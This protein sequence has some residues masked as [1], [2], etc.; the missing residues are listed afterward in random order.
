MT[1]LVVLG[2]GEGRTATI[3]VG[4]TTP[5]A[6]L[7]VGPSVVVTGSHGTLVVTDKG[8][9]LLHVEGSTSEPC[10]PLQWQTLFLDYVRAV[11][12]SPV[13]G[14]ELP[15]LAD[16]RNAYRTLSR[17]SEVGVPSESSTVTA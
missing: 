13:G 11:V 9:R 14:S 7:S 5:H 1:A 10:Q 6:Q 4:Y 15:D 3:D 17:T 12:A 8:A 16:L 2:S